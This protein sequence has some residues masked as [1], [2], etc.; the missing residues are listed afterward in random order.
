MVV[1]MKYIKKMKMFHII[2]C[3]ALIIAI[4]FMCA[5]CITNDDF[6][7]PDLTDVNL[8]ETDL[9]IPTEPSQKEKI[10]EGESGIFFD[11]STEIIEVTSFDGYTFKGKLTLPKGAKNVSKLVIYV[12]G[13]GPHTYDNRSD[14][15]NVF[16]IFANKFSDCGV[17]FFSYNT[18]G[19]DVSSKPPLYKTINEDEYQTYLPLNSLED[20][21]HMIITIKRN[22]RLK[23]CAVY[24]LGASEGTIIAPLV[25]EKY[26]NIV[27]GLFLWGYANQNMKDIL[28]WQNTGGPSMVFYRNYFEADEQ[29]RVS[30]EAYESDPYNVISS[31]LANSAFESIDTN[32]DGY[33]T[34]EDF[35]PI[36]KNVVGYDLEE[37]LSAIERRDDGWLK[38]N[39]GVINGHSVLPLTAAWF[40]QHFTLRSNM[41]VLP[42]LNLPIYIFHG[43]LDQSVDVREVYKINERFKEL[44]KNNLTINIFENHSHDLNFIDII[45]KNEM[46]AGIQAIFDTIHA[47]E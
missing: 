14:T 15:F 45:Q 38:N 22:E 43:T 41:E 36:W 42:N 26:P 32:G 34:E 35:F 27:D 37:L 1:F 17:A 11:A 5:S 23:N 19:V 21:Y 25:A 39:Y 30:R 40:L 20:V 31:I 47:M 18:R 46:P 33:I 10:D 9:A 8:I 28:I 4:L 6:E 29:G 12:N 7:N 16:D 13:S 24:L 44:G 2:V 3:F